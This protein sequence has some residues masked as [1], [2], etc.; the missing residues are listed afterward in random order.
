MGREGACFVTATDAVIARSPDVEVRSTVGAG[1]AMVAGIVAARI[2]G[3][4]LDECARLAS[5]FSLE[6]LTR[7]E[8]GIP[9]QTALEE[10]MKQITVE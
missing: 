3:L 1:D 4:P 7:V 10:A 6:A 9:S 2:R 8:S 5:A